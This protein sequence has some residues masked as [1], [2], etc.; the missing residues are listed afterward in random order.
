MFCIPFYAVAVITF[1]KH[2][3]TDTLDSVSPHSVVL[4]AS[5]GLKGTG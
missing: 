2:R 1:V 5:M 4:Y 3:V